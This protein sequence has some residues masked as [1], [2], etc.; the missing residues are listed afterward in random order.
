VGNIIQRGRMVVRPGSRNMG[1]ALLVCTFFVGLVFTGACGNGQPVIPTPEQSGGVLKGITL[2]PRSFQSADFTDFFDKAK[3]AGV[4]VSWSGDWN[5]LGNTA[6]GPTVIME[7]AST[8]NYTPL[9]EVQFFTQSTGMLLRPLDDS[10]KEAYK[11]STVAFVSKYKVK[12]LGIGIEVDTL[13][14]KSPADFDAFVQL[15]SEVY[16]AVKAKSPNTRVF[17]IFQLE[18]LKGLNGGLFG[19]TND[20]ANAQW[21]LLDRFPK[22]DII[23]FTTYPSLIYRDPSEIPLDYYSEIKA[24]TEKPVAFTEIGWHSEPGPVGWESSEAEQAEFIATFFNSTGDLNKELVIWSFMYDQ[25]TLAPFRSMGLYGK[26]GT[27]KL[28]WNEWV[29][30][31]FAFY[32]VICALKKAE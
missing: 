28:A 7:L 12:Y 5:E 13:Y 20:P 21:S 32:F 11:N 29:S 8:Y 18:K 23:A 27:A 6:G 31:T 16:D 4:V 26:D 15:Y 2:S 25:D 14:A 10:T 1:T 22:S 9:V 30:S 3:Q 17:T 24:H 19:G